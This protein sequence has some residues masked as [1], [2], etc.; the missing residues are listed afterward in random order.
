MPH[1][2]VVGPRPNRCENGSWFD[3]VL[4]WHEAS[5]ADPEHVLFLRYEDML[6]DRAGTI[7]Q[8]ADF[9][10]IETTPEIIDKVGNRYWLQFPLAGCTPRMGLAMRVGPCAW[11]GPD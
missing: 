11:N 4:E 9:V 8:I 2:L 1:A 5:K 10:E 3:H 6:T 7:K